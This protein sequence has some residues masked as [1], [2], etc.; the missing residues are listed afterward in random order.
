MTIISHQDLSFALF[1]AKTSHFYIEFAKG[2][3]SGEGR[4]VGCSVVLVRE[5]GKGIY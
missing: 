5:F 2:T 3:R 1:S 4:R